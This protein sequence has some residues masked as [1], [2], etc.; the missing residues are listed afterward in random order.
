MFLF[1]YIH[2]HIVPNVRTADDALLVIRTMVFFHLQ[3]INKMLDSTND[4]VADFV[5]GISADVIQFCQERTFEQFKV[6]NSQLNKI[7][8]YKQLRNRCDTIGYGLNKVIFRG[9]LS[10]GRLQKMHDEAI[11]KRTSLVL[12]RE[13]EEQVQRLNDFKLTKQK[14]RMMQEIQMESEKLKA[15]LERE[16]KTNDAKLEIANNEHIQRIKHREEA[17]LVETKRLEQWKSLG[18]D[19]TQYLV[20]EQQKNVEK[21]IQINNNSSNPPNGVNFTAKL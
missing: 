9:Y 16:K 5:N 13:N 20:A 7:E 18:I 15:S 3:D 17:S 11:E 4:P 21:L 6:D 12:E 14:E 1:T 8:T 2:S 19:L 10:S